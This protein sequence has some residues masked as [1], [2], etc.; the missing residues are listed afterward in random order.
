MGEICQ[1]RHVELDHLQCQLPARLVEGSDA[2]ESGIVDEEIDGDVVVAQESDNPV[3][4][5]TLR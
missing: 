2:T 3:D 4:G 1:Y 5:A